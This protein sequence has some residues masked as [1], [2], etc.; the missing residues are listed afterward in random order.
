MAAIGKRNML[1]VV[2]DLPQGLYLDGGQL[3]EILLPRRYVPDNYHPQGVI[4]VFVYRDSE[5]RLV[6]TTEKPFAMVG[7]FACLKVTGVHRTA[8]AFLDWGLTKD[9]LLPFREQDGPVRIGDKV[10][11]AIDLDEKSGRI[12]ASAR[13]RRYLS[14]EFPNYRTGQRVRMLISRRTPLG[15]EAIV[16]N[17]HLGLLFGNNIVTPLEIGAK[18]DGFVR[19]VRPDGKIDLSLDALGYQKVGSLQRQVVQALQKNGGRLTLDDDSSPADIRAAFGVSK[20]AWKQTLGA[21]Y[22]DRRIAFTRPGIELIESKES[23]AEGQSETD[24]R[25]PQKPLKPMVKPTPQKKMPVEQ[26]SRLRK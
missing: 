26:K 22:K 21:L 5:D 20:K 12:I 13:L 7:E 24:H 4:D 25:S 16:E 1:G 19:A 8:G 9:L 14:P 3:G 10:I 15:Y 17:N 2:K 6:A 23:A 11:V 18:S